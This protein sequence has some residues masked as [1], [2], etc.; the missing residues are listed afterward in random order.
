MRVKLRLEAQLDER[1][2][3][4]TPWAIRLAGTSTDWTTVRGGA[5]I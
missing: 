5:G 2:V 4:E 1:L 3:V